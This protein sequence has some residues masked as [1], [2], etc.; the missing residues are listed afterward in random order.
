M[1]LSNVGPT[2]SDIT[3]IH[4]SWDIKIANLSNIFLKFLPTKK[5]QNLGYKEVKKVNITNFIN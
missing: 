2:L 4:K 3:S 5:K 1:A